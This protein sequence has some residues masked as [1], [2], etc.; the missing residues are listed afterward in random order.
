MKKTYTI[1][2]VGDSDSAMCAIYAPFDVKEEFGTRGRVPIKGTINGHPYRSSLAN[3]GGGRHFMPVRK[4]LQLAAGIKAGDTVEWVVERDTEERTVEVPE[5]LAD[6]FKNNKAAREIWERLSY[7]HQREYAEWITG[8]KK[9]E[10]RQRR[11]ASAIEMLTSGVK[12]P[13]QPGK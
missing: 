2:L 10:T 13:H 6:E 7:T 11:I 3:M 5:R 9:D 1:E 12:T 8:A 4:S